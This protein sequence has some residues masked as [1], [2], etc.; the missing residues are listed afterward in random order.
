MSQYYSR[1]HIK[2]SSIK[3]WERFEGNNDFDLQDIISFLTFSG[4]EGSTSCVLDDWSWREL[5][6]E[7]M[8][9]ALAKVLDRDGIVIAD[10]HNINV[11][12]YN[13]CVYYLGG[14]E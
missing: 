7:D 8:V 4:K 3:V 10:T 14:R 13:H 5:E 2:V 12:R 1:I 6:L 9:K 11:D